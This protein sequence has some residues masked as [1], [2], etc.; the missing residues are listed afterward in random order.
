MLD[1]DGISQTAFADDHAGILPHLAL[2][3][4]HALL[5]MRISGPER[6]ER[7]E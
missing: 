4:N 7:V 5:E 1:K 6:A 3:Q 2:K